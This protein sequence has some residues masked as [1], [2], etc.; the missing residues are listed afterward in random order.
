[1]ML[2]TKD[3]V[4][5]IV[6]MGRKTLKFVHRNLPS[7]V[8]YE[9]IVGNRE[10]QIARQGPVVVRT[11]DFSEVPASDKFVVKR[12]GEETQG[13]QEMSADQFSQLVYRVA[14]YLQNKE[15]FVQYCYAGQ[16]PDY[17]ISLRIVTET[18]WHS[19]FARNMFP[20]I[21]GVSDYS[22]L[23]TDF[24]VIHIP[25]FHA[26][27]E[28]DGTRSRSAVILNM[29]Q[30]LIFIC[31]TSYA[32]EIRQAVFTLLHHQLPLEAAFPMRCAANTGAENDVAI[33]VG[34]GGSG[35]TTLAADPERRLIGDHIHGWTDKGLFNFEH[36][37]YAR[38]LNLSRADEP[39]IF[40]CAERF[41]TIL[42]NVS[43]DLET[44]KI[45]LNDKTLTENTRAAYPLKIMPNPVTEGVSGHPRHLFLVTCDAFGVMPAIARLTPELAVYAFMS[46]YTSRFTETETETP[47]PDI[48]FNTCFGASSMILPAHIYGKGLLER[49]K[50]HNVSCWLMNTGWIGDP[51]GR[52]ER[53]KI[54]TSRA[55]IRAAISGQLDNADYETDPVFRFET[56]TSCPGVPSQILNP[57]N[58][59]QDPGEY[60]V[61]ANAL[62]REF[63]KDFE[64]FEDQMPETMRTML[65]EVL[66]PDDNFDMLE[67]FGISM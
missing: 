43:V 13:P 58:A 26:V 45:D 59:A 38:V 39:D 6:A 46:G 23:E 24:S 57:R 20:E 31:G 5:D 17:R 29:P 37:A 21:Q 67:E 62:A 61:R 1:M 16:D 60:E 11:G 50:T 14:A 32:G 33:F 42:E 7:A 4:I 12:E 30:K 25:G 27:P 52:G 66:S 41:R 49:I 48:M 18:A 22:T 35:K 34:R 9:R 15:I 10:G 36:G 44:R 2:E 63:M 3:G 55:L 40:R 19:L 65:S 64:Q 51:I 56:P 47:Q 28:I 53:I 8:L 54:P